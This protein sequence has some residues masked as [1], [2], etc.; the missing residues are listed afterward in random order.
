MSPRV[1]RHTRLGQQPPRWRETRD[2]P[3]WH[4]VPTDV[5]G[6]ELREELQLTVGQVVMDPPGHSD[7][8][9]A[10]GESVDQPSPGEAGAGSRRGDEARLL[11]HAGAANVP[12]IRQ[13]E[14]PLLG[15][16]W[17]S[18]RFWTVLVLLMGHSA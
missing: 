2:T 1:I 4:F 5:E 16:A 15:K 17:N 13:D 12:G 6:R 3:P 11:E 9:R 7:P 8:G 18:A 10:L 14:T